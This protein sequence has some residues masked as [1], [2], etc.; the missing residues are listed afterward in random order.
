M[1]LKIEVLCL[2][3]QM[4]Q[5]NQGHGIFFYGL[6]LADE[7]LSSVS[8]PDVGAVQPSLSSSKWKPTNLL[9]DMSNTLF[10]FICMSFKDLFHEEGRTF[11]ALLVSH[12]RTTSIT[13]GLVRNAESQVPACT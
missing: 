8:I 3:V 13:W 2:G 12:S 1:H 10:I 9:H 11:R 5:G 6:A 4:V 7:S